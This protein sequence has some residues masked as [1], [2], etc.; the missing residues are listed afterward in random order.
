MAATSPPDPDQPIIDRQR[1]IALLWESV[2]TATRGQLAAAL[3]T[4]DPGIG[5][6]R[7]L[8]RSLRGR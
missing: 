6:T 8:T 7:L 4:G 2:E 1:E 5:K 3:M